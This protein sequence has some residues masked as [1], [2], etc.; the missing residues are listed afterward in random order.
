[1]ARHQGIDGRSVVGIQPTA[2]DEVVRQKASLVECPGLEGGDELDLVDQT[3][4]QSEQA[5]E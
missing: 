4:L 5:K 3:V 1:V 2:G